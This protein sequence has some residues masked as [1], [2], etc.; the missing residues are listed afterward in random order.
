MPKIIKAKPKTTAVR[1]KKPAPK[2]PTVAKVLPKGSAKI[3]RPVKPKIG[4]TSL[5]GQGSPDNQSENHKLPIIRG[6]RLDSGQDLYYPPQWN[7]KVKA[8]SKPHNG[9]PR[10]VKGVQVALDRH[11]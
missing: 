9:K 11:Y 2:P 8:A 6:K 5:L 4:K 10:R 1:I 3:P 7:W